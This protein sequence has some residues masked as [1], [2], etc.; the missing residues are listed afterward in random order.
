MIITTDPDEFRSQ[1]EISNPTSGQV[2]P[3]QRQDTIY[4][5]LA[6]AVLALVAPTTSILDANL[7][8][9]LLH[10][11]IDTLR[12]IPLEQLP[13]YEGVGRSV[14]Y[15]KADIEDFVSKRKKHSRRGAGLGCLKERSLPTPLIEDQNPARLELLEMKGR[16]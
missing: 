14:L 2:F 10:C 15:M 13:T 11:S 6:T 7:A 16:G 8:A 4:D 3:I 12:R 5:E 9:S 1:L